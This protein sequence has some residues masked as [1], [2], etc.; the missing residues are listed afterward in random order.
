MNLITASS[1]PIAALNCLAL[2]ILHRRVGFQAQPVSGEQA[3]R[4]I[5]RL[6]ILSKP[7]K[8]H[9][10]DRDGRYMVAF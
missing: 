8:T 9:I 7:L 1:M 6:N 3:T 2:D 4:I 10:Q 5:E